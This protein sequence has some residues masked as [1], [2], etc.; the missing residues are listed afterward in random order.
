MIK[1]YKTYCVRPIE[2]SNNPRQPTTRA[3]F[4]HSSVLIEFRVG[5]EIRRKG[6]GGVPPCVWGLISCRRRSSRVVKAYK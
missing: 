4:D 1:S 6:S 3:K 2:S 5:V